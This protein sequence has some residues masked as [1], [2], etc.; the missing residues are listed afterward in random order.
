MD[1]LFRILIHKSNS[2]NHQQHLSSRIHRPIFP[3]HG[4]INVDVIA[5]MTRWTWESGFRRGNQ[6]QTEALPLKSR[7]LRQSVLLFY[8]KSPSMQELQPLRLSKRPHSAVWSPLVSSKPLLAKS[9]LKPWI[10]KNWHMPPQPVMNA[11]E[12]NWKVFGTKKECVLR[13]S[14]HSLLANSRSRFNDRPILFQSQC[15][16]AKLPSGNLT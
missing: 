2:P 5:E 3:C 9:K 4:A 16:V 13:C 12:Q 7:V 10:D 15:L 8:N 11:C 14:E 6:S 1:S